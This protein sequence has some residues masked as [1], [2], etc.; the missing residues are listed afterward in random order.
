[1]RIAVILRFELIGPITSGPQPAVHRF[2][3]ANDRAPLL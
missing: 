2:Q 3:S 1:L